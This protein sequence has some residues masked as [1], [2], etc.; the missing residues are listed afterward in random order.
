VLLPLRAMYAALRY[1]IRVRQLGATVATPSVRTRCRPI[2]ALDLISIEGDVAIRPGLTSKRPSVRGSTCTS[3][4]FISSAVARSG[5]EP[6]FA[7][8]VTVAAAPGSLPLTP[9]LASVGS[10]RSGKAPAPSS[11]RCTR[12]EAHG[13][14]LSVRVSDLANWRP[15]PPADIPVLLAHCGPHRPRSSGSPAPWY[16]PEKLNFPSNISGDAAVRGV[17]W[18]LLLLV[19][20]SWVTVVVTSLLGCLFIRWTAVSRV[21]YPSRGLS[22]ALLMY[23]MKRLKRHPETVD[24]GA[25]PGSTWGSRLHATSAAWRLRVRRH[26][27]PRP[28]VAAA[29]SQIFLL[30][31]MF[32]EHARL[33]RRAFK[34]RARYAPDFFRRLTI[35]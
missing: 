23:R 4:R 8:N 19:I 5:R 7:S 31:W 32:H 15:S 33:W 26:V 14:R 10:R 12:A 24:L 35:A 17:V 1:G 6:P 30:Q 13:D 18:H 20:V 28:E 2:E 11:G 16:P 9:I 25:S 3:V 29:D 22:G 21:C 34:L 27:Q